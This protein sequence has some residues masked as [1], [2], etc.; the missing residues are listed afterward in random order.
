[1]LGAR[2]WGDK[3]HMAHDKR[4]PIVSVTRSRIVKLV[5]RRAPRRS[6]EQFHAVDESVARVAD[7][8]ALPAPQTDAPAETARG[9]DRRPDTRTRVLLVAADRR[10]RTVASALLTRRGYFVTARERA[11]DIAELAAAER[12]HVVVIDASASLT[13]TAHDA[14]RLLAL[15]PPV[16]IVAVSSEQHQSLAALPVLEKWSSFDALFAAIERARRSPGRKR[17]PDGRP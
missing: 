2:A 1:M 4:R 9:G 17:G 12:A 14:A 15:N 8:G 13:A 3:G 6:E 7:G 11:D 10:F 16:G 5:Q